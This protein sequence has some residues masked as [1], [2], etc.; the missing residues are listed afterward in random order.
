[1][2]VF[3]P[4]SPQ[5]IQ[6]MHGYLSVPSG[7]VNFYLMVEDF[8]ADFVKMNTEYFRTLPVV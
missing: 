1:V 4:R 6:P 5:P 8:A 2:V 3:G 7:I